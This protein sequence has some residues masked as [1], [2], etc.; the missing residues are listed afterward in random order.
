[1]LSSPPVFAASDTLVLAI[2]PVLNEAKTRA[3]FKPLAKYIENAAGIKCVIR[4]SPNFFAYWDTTR[5]GKEYNLVLDAAHFT[6]YRIQKFGY[7][8]LAKLPDTVSYSLV[9]RDDLPIIDP[10]ELV[11]RSIATLGVPSV[12]AARLNAMFPNPA[13]QPIIVE[14]ASTEEGMKMLLDKKVFAAI[15]PTP[16]IARQMAEGAGIQLVTTTEPIPHMAISAATSVD[17]NIREKIRQALL[18][19]NANNNGI[20]MLK[21]IGF[22]RFEPATADIYKGYSTT[23]KEYWGY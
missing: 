23:L 16:I 12:G 1:M 9:V 17:P 3:V 7:E 6:D 20:E 11:G 22:E 10:L 18:T 2:Q 19:A 5:K 13:R 4:T 14:A 15:M 8:V 21:R